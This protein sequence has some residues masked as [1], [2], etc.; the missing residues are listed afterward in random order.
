M[1]RFFL[2]SLAT[3]RLTV[4]HL[5]RPQRSFWLAGVLAISL[6]LISCTAN[7]P[8]AKSTPAA[9]AALKAQVLQ[10]IRENPQVVVDSVQ[11]YQ[12]QQQQQVQQARQTFLQQMIVNPASV[13]GD[14][15]TTGAADRKVVLVEFS[16]FQCP[17]CSKAHKTVKQ[18]MDKHKDK[19]TLTYKH[20]PLTQLH[21]EA[22]PAAKAAWAAQQQGKFWEYHD[23]LFNQSD[24]LG[25]PLYGTIAKNLKLDEARFNKDRQSAAAEAA[26]QKDV[27]MAESLGISGTPFFTLN[28]ETLAGAIELPELEKALERVVGASPT[29]AQ[30]EQPAE[31]QTETP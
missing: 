28:G 4:G 15:P 7:K 25:E 1:R 8:A 20:L 10:I 16:D 19:V 27:Q 13:I 17:F 9:D 6:S 2:N 30:T 5:S 3:L 11:A 14:S 21:P 29:P 31:P 26:I 12:Q 24:K 22:L 23:A 18:F